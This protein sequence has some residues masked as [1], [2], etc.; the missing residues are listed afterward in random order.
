M[1]TILWTVTICLGAMVFLLYAISLIMIW[2]WF[3][4]WRK[5][6]YHD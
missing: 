1:T 2:D 5:R 4:A 6:G 3:K